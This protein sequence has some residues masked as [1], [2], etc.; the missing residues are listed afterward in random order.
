MEYVQKSEYLSHASAA[1]FAS[2]L[3][4]AHGLFGPFQLMTNF[5]G[6]LRG[7][8]GADF[9]NQVFSAFDLSGNFQNSILIIFEDF[10]FDFSYNPSIV[11]DRYALN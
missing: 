4:Q 1:S 2:I 10:Q 6:L 8:I 3:D 5:A 7:S 11:W 9:C